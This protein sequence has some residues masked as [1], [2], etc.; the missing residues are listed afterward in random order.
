MAPSTVASRTGGRTTFG[1][2]V[3]ACQF[4]YGGWFLFHG[5]NYWLEFYLDRSIQPGPGLVPA[6]A[7]SGVMALVKALEVTIGLALL[8][9]LF[10]ALAVVAAWP[11][12]LMIAFVTASHGRPFGMGVAAVIIGLNAVMSFGYLHRYRPMLA[13]SAG[14]PGG[15]TAAHGL[16]MVP[17][18]HGLAALMGIAA[19]IGITYLTV[20]LRR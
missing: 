16:R 9:D 1:S 6:L 3:Y 18:R 8:L 19:A 11:I 7:E 13:W 12:T 17:A 5:L 10:A 2:V 15:S 20:Y 4:L 14:P